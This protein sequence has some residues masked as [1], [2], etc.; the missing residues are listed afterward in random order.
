[1]CSKCRDQEAR[2]K[3]KREVMSLE[4]LEIGNGCQLKYYK[5]CGVSL[6]YTEHQADSWYT[7]T[8]TEVDIDKDK[9]VEIVAWLCDKYN[10][11]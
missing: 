10:L 5:W 4:K 9:A 6:C 8:E 3:Q 11:G 1:M 7:N 2:Q